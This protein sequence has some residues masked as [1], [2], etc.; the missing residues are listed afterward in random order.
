MTTREKATI[1]SEPA[2]SLRVSPR[3]AGHCA[4]PA[5]RLAWESVCSELPGSP[6]LDRVS[7]PRSQGMGVRIGR[8]TAYGV[9]PLDLHAQ[10]ADNAGKTAADRAGASAHPLPCR[11][12]LRPFPGHGLKAPSPGSSQSSRAHARAKQAR[13][14]ERFQVT[15]VSSSRAEGLQTDGRRI[16]ATGRGGVRS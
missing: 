11:E 10:T 5:F 13:R 8:T 6:S 2:D 12:R 4:L 16:D 7:Y 9:K 15:G 14:L 1:A 3:R